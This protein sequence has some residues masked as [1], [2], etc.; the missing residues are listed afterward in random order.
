VSLLNAQLS[1]PSQAKHDSV[2][3]T[4]LMLCHYRMCETGIAQFKTQFAGVKKLMGMRNAGPSTSTAGCNWGWMETAF[5]FF[6][7]IT[8]SVN[9]REAQLR[10][11]YLDMAASPYA[12][13]YALENLAGCDGRLFKIIAVLGRLNLLSQGRQVLSPLPGSSEHAASLR[14]PPAQAQPAL[15]EYYRQYAGQFGTTLNAA[16][17]PTSPTPSPPLPSNNSSSSTDD[18][19][20]FWNEWRSTRQALQAWTFSPASLLTS[21]APVVPSPSQIRDFGFVSEAFRHAALLYTE[22]LAAPGLPSADLR[23]QSHVGQVLFYVTQLGGEQGEVGSEAMGKFLLWPLFV[24]GSEAVGEYERG[25]VRERCRG[26]TR[27]GGYA[28]NLAGLQILEKLWREGDEAVVSGKSVVGDGEN[29]FRWKRFMR[30]V[31][32][33]YIM[34]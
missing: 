28:N 12:P 20:Q 18:S 19:T 31:E 6:D 26:I 32:G 27:R 29:H 3:A 1:D 13:A 14:N 9:D 34:V 7:A 25:V 17:W 2:L 5:T 16:G 21:L 22:R 33:E 10:G 24:A 4:L 23:F 30:E 8:A 11:G 15:N